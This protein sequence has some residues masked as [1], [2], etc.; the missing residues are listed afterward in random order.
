MNQKLGTI[1]IATNLVNGKQYVGQ[2]TKNLKRRIRGHKNKRNYPISNAIKKYGIENF[3]W[4][5]FSCPEEDLD[6]QESFLIKEL[7]TLAPYGYNLETGGNKN[8]HLHKSTREIMSINMIKRLRNKKNH[9]MF[10]RK[11]KE[12]EKPYKLTLEIAQLIRQRVKNGEKEI[13][14]AKE[15]NVHRKTISKIKNH[16]IYII[17]GENK[18]FNNYGNRKLT[19]NEITTIRKKISNKEKQKNIAKEYNVG[20]YTISAIKNNKSYIGE[21]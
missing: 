17:D 5:S 11:R 19:N 8:K 3:K 14:I 1:Y 4:I 13:D 6:W 2:T 7:N 20:F 15:Y 16:K 10:G 21:I 18:I 9:P 12:E